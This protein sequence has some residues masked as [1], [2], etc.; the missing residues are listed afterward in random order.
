MQLLFFGSLSEIAGA[1]GRA[2]LVADTD[3]LKEKLQRQYPLLKDLKYAVAVDKKII[4]SN[5]VLHDGC[6]VALLPPYSGG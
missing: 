3:A 1:A 5:T 2:D 6:T 4:H